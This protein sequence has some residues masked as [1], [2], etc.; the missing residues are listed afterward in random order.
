MGKEVEALD[1]GG[2]FQCIEYLVDQ[3]RRNGFSCE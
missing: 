3:L 2:V 1:A